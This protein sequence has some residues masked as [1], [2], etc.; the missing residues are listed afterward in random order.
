MDML[1]F[2]GTLLAVLLGGFLVIKLILHKKSSG[3]RAKYYSVP[4]DGRLKQRHTGRAH[5]RHQTSLS[6]EHSE[7]LWK[8]DHHRHK[9]SSWQSSSFTANKIQTDA[10]K[11]QQSR[12]Q[13]E[14]LAMPVVEYGPTE[15]SS[16][17]AGAGAA[18]RGSQGL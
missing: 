1:M 11:Q 6:K 12:K 9:E 18:K 7:D 14:G 4:V 15:P 8:A 10:E 16:R 5:L 17:P 2:L 3:R 13:H